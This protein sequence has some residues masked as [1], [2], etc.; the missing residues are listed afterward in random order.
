MQPN[1]LLAA[2][3]KYPTDFNGLPAEVSA[4]QADPHRL[5]TQFTQRQGHGAEV[6]QSTTTTHK[7][8]YLI[9]QVSLNILRQTNS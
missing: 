2:E 5:V 7:K 6:Q 4:V 9:N 8:K 3:S 1:S